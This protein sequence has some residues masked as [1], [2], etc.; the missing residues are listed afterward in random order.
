[1]F[2]NLP[3]PLLWLIAILMLL[4]SLDGIGTRKLANPDE[5]RYSEIS[6]Q[7]AQSGD[8]VTP[9]LN[10][11][12][13]FEKPPLQ[14]WTSAVSFKV[15]GFTEFA[16][17]FYT[18][19]CGLACLLLAA[20]TARRLFD[21]ETGWMCGLV[22]LS[23]PYF[24]A[25][26]E[27][28]TLDMGLT[29]WM[30]LTVCAY[31]IAER[32]TTPAARLRWMMAAWAG[33]AGAVLS[34][35]LIGI[36]F[37]AAAIFFYCV[38]HRDFTRLAR[39]SWLPGLALFFALTVPWFALV[40][41]ANPEFPR[42][43]FI[44]EHIERFTSTTHR[45]EE[46][47]WYFLPILFAGFLP[48]ALAL[49][50]AF[51]RAWRR[52]PQ[53]DANGHAFS[54]LRFVLIYA[55]FVLVFFSF[56]GSKLPAYI[57]PF[58]PLLAIVVGAYLK[59]VE[60][61]QLAWMVLPVAAL[62]AACVPWAQ[63]AV[64]KRGAEAFSLPLYQAMGE[65]VVIAC[66]L[67]GG[68]SVAAFFLLRNERKAWGIVILAVGTM[69]GVEALERGYD[70]ISP[71]QSAHDLAKAVQRAVTPGTSVYSIKHHE[72]GLPF[73]LNRDVTLVEYQDEFETGLK[74]EPKKSIARLADLP[75]AWNAPGSAV[76]IIEPYRL[77]EFKALGLPFKLIHHDPRRLALQKIDP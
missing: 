55:A 65:W 46:A 53:M 64:A 57:L 66:A 41:L 45:R 32:S 59:Q 51:R 52:A 35:G 62:A 8:F 58:F 28:V 63:S 56:S 37:P 23:S 42:F 7:M 33:T 47:W 11:I 40:S 3:R 54:P 12:K 69:M 50:P 71:L 44:H 18:A 27:I 60:S 2:S 26:S 43:F 34:K 14:Y 19:L 75:A 16:A 38:L 13:Y 22:L 67:I 73:Y 17:R 72:Q 1:M 9:R 30:T 76:A 15:F 77:D 6:R 24:A 20:Y 39:L 31:L 21:A 25:M 74:A 48:W 68:A 70:N 4:V 5:G 49:L 29:F 36:V 61:R 10:G